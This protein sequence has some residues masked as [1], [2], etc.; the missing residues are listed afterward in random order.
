MKNDIN[1]S[2]HE[3]SIITNRSYSV[4]VNEFI[5]LQTIEA[6]FGLLGSPWPEGHWTSKTNSPKTVLYEYCLFYFFTKEQ[7]N[8]CKNDKHVQNNWLRCRLPNLIHLVSSCLPPK[9]N[10]VNKM[11]YKNWTS[12]YSR[13][14]NFLLSIDNHVGIVIWEDIIQCLSRSNSKQAAH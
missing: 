13:C 14:F 10:A 6:S 7:C 8:V 5:A 9:C 4:V 1:K 12:G 3:I 11:H 2:K